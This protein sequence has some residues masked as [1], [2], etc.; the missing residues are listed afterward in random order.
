MSIAPRRMAVA[1][2]GGNLGA[3][4]GG[5][6]GHL[7]PG[8][9]VIGEADFVHHDVVI[10][11]Y[12]DAGRHLTVAA[13]SSAG[14]SLE[15]TIPAIQFAAAQMYHDIGTEDGVELFAGA[16]DRLPDKVQANVINSLLSHSDGERTGPP[17]DGALSR[18]FGDALLDEWAED[19]EFKAGVVGARMEQI[20]SGLSGAEKR[21]VD[22]FFTSAP[23][24][25][26]TAILR[27][28]S[29]SEAIQTRSDFKKMK[30]DRAR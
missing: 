4:V 23:E 14:R 2:A 19:A 26:W 28:L 30:Q 24:A 8:A 11:D 22:H 10:D 5:R 13:L 7:L 9:P 3:D 27:Q 1:T 15:T 17:P 6:R 18:D 25:E 16:Y 21:E 20:Y 29:N 12:W